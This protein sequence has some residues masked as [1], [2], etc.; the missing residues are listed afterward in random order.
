MVQPN[1]YIYGHHDDFASPV[2]IERYKLIFFL[3]PGVEE[4]TFIHLLRRMMGYKDWY[5]ST[6]QEGLAHLYDYNISY[7]SKLMTDPTF[8][9]A[10][11]VR[12][13]TERILVAYG[14]ESL[15]MQC[16]VPPRDEA[17]CRQIL[18]RFG[19]FLDAIHVCD[20]P[21]WRPQGKRMESKYFDTINFVGHME[22]MQQDAHRLLL[23]VGAWDE[24]GRTGWTDAFGNGS[25]FFNI[26]SHDTWNCSF[27]GMKP[28]YGKVGV[29]Y[30]YRSDYE[31]PKLN[32]T[33]DRS[34]GCNA[35]KSDR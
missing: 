8:I 4:E 13:P 30:F 1:D 22:T 15:R 34:C 3:I 35:R 16:C 2:V 19:N 21:H 24:Y 6:S 26:S 5:S 23:R 32:L 25:L 20:R 29:N 10:I 7:A 12:D 9:R 11:F 17:W 27:P 31:N 14:N 28:C 33:V 18:S